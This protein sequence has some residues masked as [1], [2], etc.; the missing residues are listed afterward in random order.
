MPV[1]VFRSKVTDTFVINSWKGIDQNQPSS[2]LIKTAGE[3]K[4]LFNFS[5]TLYSNI[6]F[7]IKKISCLVKGSLRGVCRIGVEFPVFIL[8]LSNTSL[9]RVLLGAD[10][11]CKFYYKLTLQY[12]V[13]LAT[14]LGLERCTSNNKAYSDITVGS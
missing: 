11:A 6:S 2:L 7:T 12:I 13:W 5:V 10:A 3:D 14:Q 4:G 1:A 9:T 8:E